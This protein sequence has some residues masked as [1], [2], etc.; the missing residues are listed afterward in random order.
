MMA[1]TQICTQM[2]V[3]PELRAQADMLA[4][5]ENPVNGSQITAGGPVSTAPPEAGFLA[6]PVGTMWKTGRTLRV[7]I[8][9]GSDNIKSKIQG[10]PEHAHGVDRAEQPGPAAGPWAAPE[11]ERRLGVQGRHELTY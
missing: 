11:A 7:K 1:F 4:V 5:Q 6:L 2:P 3:P 10:L 9:N 8:L